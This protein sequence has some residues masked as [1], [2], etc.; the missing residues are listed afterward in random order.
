MVTRAD[1]PRNSGSET[2]S[3]LRV[4]Y[5]KGTSRADSMRLSISDTDEN[6]EQENIQGVW[7]TPCKNK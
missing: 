2:S 5:L 6:P 7:N 3:R 1:I 4:K